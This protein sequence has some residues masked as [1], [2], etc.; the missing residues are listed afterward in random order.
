[1]LPYI[2]SHER[3]LKIDIINIALSILDPTLIV[4]SVNK[5]PYQR[6]LQDFLRCKTISDAPPKAA[7]PY[8]RPR[9]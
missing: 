7:R 1:M 2:F 6:S 3:L 4:S 9:F 5:T 8:D